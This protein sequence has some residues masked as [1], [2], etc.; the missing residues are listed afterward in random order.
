MLGAGIVVYGRDSTPD[1]V[2]P[3]LSA[4]EFFRNESCGKC[5]PCRLGSQQLAELAARL[6]GG[7]YTRTE[8]VAEGA[9]P[10]VEALEQA[11]ELTSICGLGRVASNP[12]KSLITHFPEDVR[13][14]LK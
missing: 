11:L 1:M 3:A 9:E 2:G 4:S 8:W 7:G 14:H 5:V 6:A 10:M 13:A 12:L